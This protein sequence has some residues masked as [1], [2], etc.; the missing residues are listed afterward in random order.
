M[1][2][3]GASGP[4]VSPGPGKSGLAQ[5]EHNEDLFSRRFLIKDSPY[6]SKLF[7]HGEKRPYSGLTRDYIPLKEEIYGKGSLLAK[8]SSWPI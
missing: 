6:L 2:G 7:I 4:A 8:P 3:L 5:D 1:K